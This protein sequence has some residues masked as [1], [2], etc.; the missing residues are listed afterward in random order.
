MKIKTASQDIRAL[1]AKYE[2]LG[3]PIPQQVA[4][5]VNAMLVEA[6]EEADDYLADCDIPST[7]TIRVKIDAAL[8]A[9]PA[10]VLWRT[11]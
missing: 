4:E 9:A 11:E 7:R 5:P 1:S 3:A 8:T 2:A 6:L 10:V